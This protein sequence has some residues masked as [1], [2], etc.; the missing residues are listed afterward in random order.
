MDIKELGNNPK[1]SN[2]QKQS[3]N[4]KKTVMPDSV[5]INDIQTCPKEHKGVIWPYP[6]QSIADAYY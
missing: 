2:E 6:S 3:E 5:C 1:C 4:E